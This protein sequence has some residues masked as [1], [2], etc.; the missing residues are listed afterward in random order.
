MSGSTGRAPQAPRTRP[1][2]VLFGLGPKRCRMVA[3]RRPQCLCHQPLP[4][5]QSI[6]RAMELGPCHHSPELSCCPDALGSQSE[7]GRQPAW[8]VRQ[9]DGLKSASIPSPCTTDYGLGATRTANGDEVIYLDVK[10]Y[11]TTHPSSNAHK[12]HALSTSQ[13][14]VTHIT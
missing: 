5:H 2:P 13:E 7:L 8:N 11:V 10:L 14:S 4:L 9:F 12:M 3:L 1:H 6:G